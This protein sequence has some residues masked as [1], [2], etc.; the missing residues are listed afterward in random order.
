MSAGLAEAS[1]FAIVKKK[2]KRIKIRA[3]RCV[4]VSLKIALTVITGPL[5]Y[6][7]RIGQEDHEAFHISDSTYRLGTGTGPIQVGTGI[8]AGKGGRNRAAEQRGKALWG[9]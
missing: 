9:G 8:Q 4:T 2:K 7:T 3:R 6:L 5:S 1:K